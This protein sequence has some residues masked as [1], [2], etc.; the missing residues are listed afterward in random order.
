MPRSLSHLHGI[1]SSPRRA[2]AVIGV[3]VGALALSGSLKLTWSFSAFT[4]LIYYALTNLAAMRL[5]AESR[6]YP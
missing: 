3:L 5:P 2:V 6:L 4:V 1:D